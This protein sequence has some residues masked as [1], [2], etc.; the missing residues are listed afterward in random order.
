M[1]Y[2]R[3]PNVNQLYTQ[4]YDGVNQ[5]SYVVTNPSF[6]YPNGLPPGFLSTLTAEQNS[7]RFIGGDDLRAPYLIQSAIGSNVK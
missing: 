6:F 4:E 7:A 1:F 3:Y 2:I 5:V